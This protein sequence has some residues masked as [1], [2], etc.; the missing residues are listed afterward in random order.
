MSDKIGPHT[1]T[2]IGSDCTFKGELSF[3]GEMKFEGRLEGKIT[4]KGTISVGATARINGDLS[5]GKATIDGTLQ[6]NI[7][8]TDL[9]ELTST[10]QVNA[11][12]RAPK[13]IVEEGAT[14]IG[15]L[16]VSPDALKKPEKGAKKPEF[17]SEAAAT[18]VPEKK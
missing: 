14:F 7:V 15:N 1:P 13:L 6:G 8:A 9:V 11:D 3:E 18:P 17:V 10:S 4:S 2:V 16:H 12:L 5:V